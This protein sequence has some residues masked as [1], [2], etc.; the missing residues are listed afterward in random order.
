[1]A[2]YEYQVV[3]QAG[4]RTS[5]LNDRLTQLVEEGWEPIMM[6]G[7]AP[8]I[9][10]MVRRPRAQQAA[11]PAARQAQAQAAG[12]SPAP[13]GPAAQAGQ[14]VRPAQPGAAAAGVPQ[15]PVR[16]AGQ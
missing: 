7:G 12:G 14:P 6:A 15:R 2:Q 1:M 9:S 4:G 16:P 3:E 8:H 13:V 5:H 11:A 10:I